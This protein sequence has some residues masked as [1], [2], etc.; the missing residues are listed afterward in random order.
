MT[1]TSN[2]FCTSM[3]EKSLIFKAEIISRARTHGSVACPRKK[4]FKSIS[5]KC[6]KL[7]LRVVEKYVYLIELHST[8][9]GKCD[10][11]LQPVRI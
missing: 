9:G 7:L 4:N 1:P 6:Q 5:P 10:L 3:E 11:T 8:W 2:Q